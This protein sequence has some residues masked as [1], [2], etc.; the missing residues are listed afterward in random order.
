MHVGMGT[1]FQGW[2]GTLS[3]KEVYEVDVHLADLAEPLGFESI[4]GSSTTS[5]TTRCAPTSFSS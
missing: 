4:W 3:D 1:V 5:R 2:G